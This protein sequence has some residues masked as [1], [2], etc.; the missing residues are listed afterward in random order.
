MWQYFMRE[1]HKHPAQLP[2]AHRLENPKPHRRSNFKNKIML[3][4]G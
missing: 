2:Q 4:P 3:M 1:K